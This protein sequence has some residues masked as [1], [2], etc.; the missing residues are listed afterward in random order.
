M[1]STP[2]ETGLRPPIDLLELT[3]RLVDVPSESH[4]EAAITDLIESELI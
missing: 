1:S 4:D 3:A 2:A